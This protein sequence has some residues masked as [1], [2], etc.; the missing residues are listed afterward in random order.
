[1]AWW[2]A[3]ARLRDKAGLLHDFMTDSPRRAREAQARFPWLITAEDFPR[4]QTCSDYQVRQSVTEDLDRDLTQTRPANVLRLLEDVLPK[5]I[6]ILTGL[7]L[8]LGIGS[9][10]AELIGHLKH[11][12]ASYFA[13]NVIN[14]LN[15]WLV[16]TLAQQEGECRDEAMEWFDRK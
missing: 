15:G 3:R 1:L 7:H 11:T 9:Q 16:H 4:L 6:L 8:L 5:L 10:G 2:A 12:L 13:L 14:L